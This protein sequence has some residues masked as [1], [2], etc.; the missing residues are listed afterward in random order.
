[1]VWPKPT[2]QAILT[3]NGANYSDWETVMVRHALYE[4]PWI[5]FRF[6]C[7]EGMPLSKNIAALRI[8]P[9]MDCT[10]T[11]AGEPAVD[12][13]VSTRQV[14]YDA[15]RHHIE[16]QGASDT[17]GLASASVVSKTGEFKDINYEQF[18]KALL[19]PIGI[20]FLVEGGQLP[21]FKFPRIS[22]APG[23]SILEAL[24]Q[25]LRSLGGVALT[26]NPKGDVVAVVGPK[27]GED[28]VTEGVDIL[29]G[30]EIIYNPGMA[31]GLYS[32]AQKPGSNQEWG[33]KVSHL[34]FHANTG[35]GALA[36]KYAPQVV[37]LEIPGWSKDHV[38]GRGN[39]DRD[40]QNEDEVTVYATVHGWLR[41]SGGLW[42]IGQK[43]KVVSPMLVMD[44]GVTLKAKT[45]TF[46]QDN[47]TGTRTTLELV[48]P[49]AEHGQIPQ[50]AGEE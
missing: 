42:E 46:T 8:L 9:G 3:V 40:W 7:S 49:A 45:I 47:T 22:I 41:P 27:G 29:E 11:L 37:P 18:A 48:N 14:F 19:K 13:L 17:I 15:R 12:G 2:E 23:T 39:A 4:H 5:N 34:P 32:M 1:M 26:S 25:P 20:K 6:T 36:Q 16:I 24:D 35:L 30:R 33:A 50:P 31:Q 10:I 43:V 28:T 44:G 21:Q 38:K